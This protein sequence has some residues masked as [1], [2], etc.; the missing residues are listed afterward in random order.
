MMLQQAQ[1]ERRGRIGV[2]IPVTVTSVLDSTNAAIA[3]LNEEGALIKGC[4]LNVGA[5]VQIDYLEQTL[6]AQCRW[7]EID[8]MGVQ[9]LQLLTDGPLFEQL[10]TA[11]M[12]GQARNGTVMMMPFPIIQ[13]RQQSRERSFGRAL[14]GGLG[15]RAS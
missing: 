14:N 10:R 12:S 11:R 15:H 6:Y 13:A 1:I 4:S 2:D 9:F 3:D 8:R 5:R 7:A